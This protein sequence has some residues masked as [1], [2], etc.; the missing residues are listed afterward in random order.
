LSF[1]YHLPFADL[2]A[3]PFAT[4]QIYLDRLPAR[5]AEMKAEFSQVISLPWMK[6]KDRHDLLNSWQRKRDPHKKTPPVSPP[7]LKMMGIGIRH[8]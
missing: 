1:W 8:E 2:M 3:M 4:M 6:E 7:I 5:I